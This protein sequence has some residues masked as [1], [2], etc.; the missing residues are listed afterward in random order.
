MTELIEALRGPLTEI[1]LAIIA[2]ALAWAARAFAARTGIEIEARHREALQ[3]ALSAAA[4]FALDKALG[5]SNQPEIVRDLAV[6]MATD[7]VK[8]SV[9]DALAHFNVGDDRLREMI[10]PRLVAAANSTPARSEQA[11]A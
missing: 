6:T 10:A 11:G 2:F 8:R 7:Y 3:A 9:P 1:L 4:R 5:K